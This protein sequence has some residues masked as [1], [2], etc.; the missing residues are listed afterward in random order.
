[1]F[2]IASKILSFL[3]DPFFWIVVF[4][5]LGIFAKRIYRRRKYFLIGSI[6]LILFS[7]SF[8]FKKMSSFWSIEVE[9]KSP[10]NYDY[11]I[12]LGGMID[13]NSN[14]DCIKFYT[15]NDR[16]LNTIEL[17]HSKIIDKI[18]I[19]GASGSMVSELIEAD[20]IENYLV[21]IGIPKSD[22]IKETKSKNT[23][24]NAQFT[25]KIILD[26][27]LVDKPTCL[28]ITSDY[29]MRR[30]MACFYNTELEVYPYSK[31]TDI[32]FFDLEYLLIPQSDTLFSWK[33]LL[34]EIVGYYAY[35]IMG[36]T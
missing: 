1:M 13:L 33:I 22:I 11:G 30:A 5:A 12:L 34:H 14:K 31:R 10:N 20:L 17:Y 9:T 23:F 16:L 27:N 32:N 3:I 36:Y 28:I 25:E 6:L 15:N 21:R 29:H 18:I 35:K 26:N 2:F 19:T 8:I 7:N 4:F 24:Q